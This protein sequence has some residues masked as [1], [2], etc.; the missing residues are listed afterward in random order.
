MRR[1]Y[2]PE[3]AEGELTKVVELA[4]GFESELTSVGEE[5][6]EGEAGLQESDEPE[7]EVGDWHDKDVEFGIIGRCKDGSSRCCVVV[8]QGDCVG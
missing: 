3:E 7:E 6:R 2:W 8:W 1:S 5:G 4:L